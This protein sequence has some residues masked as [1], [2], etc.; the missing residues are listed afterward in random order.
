[1]LGPFA[2]AIIA[3]IGLFL[4]FLF[5]I[6]KELDKL[7]IYKTN[8]GINGTYVGTFII[9][10]GNTNAK[11]KFEVKTSE[12]G[13]YLNPKFFKYQPFNPI[14]VPWTDISIKKDRMLISFVELSIGRPVKTR[15]CIKTKN[16]N[17]IMT[18]I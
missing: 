10:I 2:L 8:K 18:S 15:I 12:L 4:I 17:K 6:Q 14:L 1:M 5:N 7:S 16:Y 11:M 9:N 3:M 13:L